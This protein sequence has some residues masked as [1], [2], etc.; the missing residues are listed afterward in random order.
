MKTTDSVR[1]I[2]PARLHAG[3]LDLN[4][5][6]GRQFGGIG[7]GLQDI[8]TV[9]S[10][11]RG[12]GDGVSGTGDARITETAT[13]LL[14]HFDIDAGVD[15][16]LEQQIPAHQGLGSGTQ[17]ALALGIA[18]G[19][20]FGINTTVEE[21]ATATGRGKRSGIGIGVFKHGGF[22]VDSGRPEQQPLPTIVSH[23][24]FPEQWRFVLVFDDSAEGISGASERDAFAALPPLD[25][26]LAAETCRLVLMQTLPGIIEQDCVCFGRSIS[27][28]QQICG[29]YFRPAQ[30][31]LFSSNAVAGAVET[32]LANGATGGGQSSW[33]P[34]GF[35]VFPDQATAQQA[36]TAVTTQQADKQTGITLLVTGAEN[37]N[38]RMQ[39]QHTNN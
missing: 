27:R 7:V 26:G 15:I 10:L 38:A 5:G 24:A 25:A 9:I 20:L 31:G 12:S 33:G 11:R 19:G 6:L 34:T 17:T 28:I 23:L 37:R 2:A 36:M 30:G 4:G 14:R 32:L 18:I 16:T 1:I 3:F 22:I 21:I 35:A 13:A 29:G 8:A 39:I